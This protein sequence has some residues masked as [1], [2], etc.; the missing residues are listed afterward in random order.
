MKITHWNT[1]GDELP[2]KSRIELKD[3]SIMHIFKII[4]TQTLNPQMCE[5]TRWN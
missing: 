4:L 3:N 5:K 2:T 1:I